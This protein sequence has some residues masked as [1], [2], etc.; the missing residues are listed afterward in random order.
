MTNSA[1]RE[2]EGAEGAK[3]RF[4]DWVLELPKELEEKFLEEVRAYEEAEH[5]QYVT[6]AER[7]GRERG[8]QEGRLTC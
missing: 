8:W 4:I 7:I 2:G 3:K 1:S 5:M 6:S